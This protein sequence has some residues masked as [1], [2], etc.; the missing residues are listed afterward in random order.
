M[1]DKALV[2]GGGGVTGIAW[3]IGVLAGLAERGIDLTQA[4]LVVGTSAGSVVGVDVRSGLSLA[5]LYQTQTA[6]VRDSEVVAKMAGRILLRY[7]TAMTF[8]RNPVLA[9]RRVGKLA[10][11]ARTEPEAVRRKVFED[12][13]PIT[14]W[15]V[16]QLKLTAVDT[17]SGDFT[18]FDAASGVDLID[19]VGASCAVPGIWPPVTIGGKRYMDGGMRSAANIDL[20]LGYRQVVVIAPLTVGFGVI[21]SAASQVRQ[22]TGQGSSVVLIKPDRAAV[23]AI[24]RN[25]LDPARRAAAAKA[26]FAQAAI[27]AAAV[28]ALWSAERAERAGPAVQPD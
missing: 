14:E 18:V 4:D 7:F 28:A 20:A 3:E 9:R 22:L 19:A 16:G 17:A 8:T 25:V 1:A 26:G 5:D 2:L 11:T 6:P 23:R 24:G 13:V 10:L 21:P 27:A 12:G 15:P